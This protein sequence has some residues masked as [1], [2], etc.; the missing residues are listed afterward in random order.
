MEVRCDR[1]K[2]ECKVESTTALGPGAA[3][4]CR[5]CGHFIVIGSRLPPVDPA[6]GVTST[7]AS[8]GIEWLVETVH[9]R[10]LRAPDLATLHRWIIE[11]RVTREDRISLDGKLWQ[12][13]GE[14]ADLVP[15]FDIVDSAERARRADTP[16][17]MILPP[18]PPAG[19]QAGS[20]ETAGQGAFPQVEDHTETKVVIAPRARFSLPIRLGLMTLVAALVAYAGIAL[21]NC[22]SRPQEVSPMLPPGEP[23]ASQL[24]PPPPVVE[25]VAAPEE[26][27][28][29]SLPEVESAADSEVKAS[30]STPHR[31]SRAAGRSASRASRAAAASGSRHPKAARSAG[32]NASP[33]LL[34]A[35]G[36]AAFSHRQFPEAIELFK[37]A[38]AG[39]PGNGTALFGLAESYRELGRKSLALKCYRHY[40][41]LLPSGPN[42]GQSRLQIRLLERKSR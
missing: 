3:V 35:Q 24:L 20:P 6:E 39:N 37:K 34:A 16:G 1:C 29:P 18:P 25:P 19:A 10:S 2:T 21:H 38:L 11:R 15:F 42:A 4:Q 22:R 33:Q 28:E 8:D 30:H 13:I 41:Q 40:V 23:T 9:G 36:Y 7:P 31:R 12:R 5:D 32:A 17:P 27:E 14:V 26:E